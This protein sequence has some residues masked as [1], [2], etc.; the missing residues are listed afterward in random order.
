[1]RFS[2]RQCKICV[3]PHSSL[4]FSVCFPA[5]NVER[6]WVYGQTDRERDKE[7]EGDLFLFIGVCESELCTMQA[8][9]HGS[10]LIIFLFFSFFSFFF[11]I[12]LTALMFVIMF[13]FLTH[14]NRP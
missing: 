10:C 7:R 14:F 3:D 2:L 8:S 13:L 1:M 12:F 6:E 4:W 9:H 11:G 5:G